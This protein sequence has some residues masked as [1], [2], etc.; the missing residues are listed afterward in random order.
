MVLFSN[1]TKSIYTSD[2]NDDIPLIATHFFRRILLVISN[3][4]VNRK[5]VIKTQMVAAVETVLDPIQRTEINQIMQR[6]GPIQIERLT[7]RVESVINKL[8]HSF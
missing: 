3:F 5:I 7:V 4:R 2:D 1:S 6:R 8:Q